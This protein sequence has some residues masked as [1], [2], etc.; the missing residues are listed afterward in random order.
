MDFAHRR[1]DMPPSPNDMPQAV[2][3]MM[4]RRASGRCE[5]AIPRYLQRTLFDL[6]VFARS[7]A[8]GITSPEVPVVE[9]HVV[10]IESGAFRIRLFAPHRRQSL[11]LVLHIHGGA[12]VLGTIDWPD[13]D[14]KCR[15]LCLDTD[16]V[17]VSVDYR[18]AP[19]HRYP[20]QIED[21]YAALSWCRAK[22]L[23]LG[24]DPE[25][26]VVMGESAGGNLAAVLAMMVRD[27]NASPLLGQVLEVPL[28]DLLTPERYP[29][30][31]TYATGFGLEADASIARNLPLYLDDAQRSDAYASPLHSSNLAG[32]APAL[33]MTAEFDILRD[34][35]NL[36]AERLAGSGVPVTHYA[37]AGHNHGSMSMYQTWQPATAWYQQL[38]AFVKQTVHQC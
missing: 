1:C 21:C 3:D 8:D 4:R 13:V 24:I 22:A 32:L 9:T 29:S 15:H 30:F 35:G 12:F 33:V 23:M 20:T 7:A 36:Y 5:P 28:V 18:L 6:D 34:S 10:E 27:R 17:V 19:E 26:V 14:A 11:P 31:S 16:C 37:G 38:V 25:R 2:Q